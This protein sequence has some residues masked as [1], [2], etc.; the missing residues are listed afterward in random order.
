MFKGF[1][2]QGMRLKEPSSFSVGTRNLIETNI[3]ESKIKPIEYSQP[4]MFT[5]KYAVGGD[6]KE[7]H[8]IPARRTID[9]INSLDFSNYLGKN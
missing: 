7:N 2:A 6:V 1:K 8:D 3:L 5:Q 4:M 9:Q